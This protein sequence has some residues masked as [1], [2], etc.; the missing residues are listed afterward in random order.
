MVAQRER[1]L[2]KGG[3]YKKLEED[4][5]ELEKAVVKLKTQVD[6]KQGTIDDEVKKTSELEAE[7]QEVFRS[8]SYLLHAI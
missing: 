4:V 7:L 5:S 3:K 8:I 1:E 2:K 6:L